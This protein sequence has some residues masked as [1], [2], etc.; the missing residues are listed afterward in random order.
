MGFLSF[1]S[2]GSHE[3]EDAI[4]AAEAARHASQS[5]DID[6]SIAAHENWLTR[7]E[8]YVAG[9]SEEHLHA[10][11]IACDD[12]CA[13]GKWIYSD[14]KRYLG[15]YAA[16]EDLRATHKMF[17]FK[18]SS[19]VSLSQANKREEAEQELANDLHKLS[20]KIKRRLLDLK[21]VD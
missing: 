16:F 7:L 1:F 20:E 13:L 3:K 15:S 10:D 18:A 5:L 4:R 14:G 21:S 11:N 19:I 2:F 17:H 8:T 9:H 6:V 12:Q